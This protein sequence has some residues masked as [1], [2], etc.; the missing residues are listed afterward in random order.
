MTN[1][2]TIIGG[3]GLRTP[4]LIHGLVEQRAAIGL[5]LR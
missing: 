3:G 4:L 1:K 2:I 5:R